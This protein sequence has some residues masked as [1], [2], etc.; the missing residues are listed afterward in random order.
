MQ[1]HSSPRA[2]TQTPT[3]TSL[4]PKSISTS[5]PTSTSTKKRKEMEDP[6][7]VPP[8]HS[9]KTSKSPHHNESD[10]VK[11]NH[12]V[13]EVVKV[14]EVAVAE[15]A[16]Q[17][18]NLD[19]VRSEL[20]GEKGK[21]LFHIK[22]QSGCTVMLKKASSNNSGASSLNFSIRAPNDEVMRQ[23]V[24]LIQDLIDTVSSNYHTR[25]SK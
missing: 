6:F 14:V 23:G 25:F 17:S 22:R 4:T 10:A 15:V 2:Q 16:S 21:H 8:Q 24:T 13:S 19:W 11:S 7:S 20:I 1:T 5:T 3:S 18:G 9:N 12:A